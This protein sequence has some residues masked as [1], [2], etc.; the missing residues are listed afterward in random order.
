M[1]WHAEAGR[2]AYVV[3]K[4]DE[5][6]E[7]LNK[8]LDRVR[9]DIVNLTKQLNEAVDLAEKARN[10]EVNATK[11]A[12]LLKGALE[13]ERSRTSNAIARSEEDRT[14]KEKIRTEL[15]R[16][17]RLRAEVDAKL[18]MMED[19]LSAERGSHAE[20]Q[21]EQGI[22]LNTLLSET[23]RKDAT[24]T[25]TIVG[26]RKRLAFVEK[27]YEK[28]KHLSENVASLSNR[29]VELTANVAREQAAGVV[30]KK[31]LESEEKLRKETCAK[32]ERFMKSLQAS[33]Q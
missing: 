1:D 9:Q 18:K 23:K 8:D 13:S 12:S 3:K 5:E 15:D 29:V 33:I 2:L 6:K 25:E 4:R 14:E 17:N 7:I 19:R 32:I 21:K 11:M 30:T 27:E 10:T 26:L 31:K 28:G 20:T 24:T 16:A 22:Q